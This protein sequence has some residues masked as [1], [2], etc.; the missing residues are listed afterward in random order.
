REPEITQYEP[1]SIEL[2]S[3][4]RG[5]V[6]AK[7]RIVLIRGRLLLAIRLPNG[8]AAG[9]YRVRIVNKSGKVEKHIEATASTENG[10]TRLKVSLETSDLSPGGY[11]LS[12][13]EPDLDEWVDYPLTVK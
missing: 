2:P 5:G 7:A 1:V 3:R 11:M 8:S 9:R 13:L 12:V 6:V 4:L 10:V